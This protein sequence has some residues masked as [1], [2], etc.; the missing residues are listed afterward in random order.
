ML[1]IEYENIYSR[2]LSLVEAYDLLEEFTS[3]SDNED[4]TDELMTEWLMSVKS[5]PRVRKIFKTLSLDKPI[6]TVNF[7]LVNSLGDEQ[8]DIDFVTEILGVGIAWKWV[9]PKYYSVLN[10]CQMLSGKEVKFYSQAN[11]MSELKN[12]YATSKLQLY[13]LIRDHNSYNNSYLRGDA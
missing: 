1:S 6:R 8:S 2:F 5:N 12:M 4:S 13:N 7:E 10:A 11:H 3:G 9:T